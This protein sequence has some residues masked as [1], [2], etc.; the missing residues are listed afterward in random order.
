MIDGG[1]DNDV[2]IGGMDADVLHGSA[3]QDI[4]ISGTTEYDDSPED[5]AL[6]SGF[7]NFALPYAS[8]VDFLQTGVVFG[9][10]TISLEAN[11]NVLGDGVEDTLR[12]GEG[13]DWFFAEVIDGI[14][15]LEDGEVV[16]LL[17]VT[18]I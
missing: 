8:R 13:L 9:D 1:L 14:T 11:V 6:L 10:T 4:L 18:E 12:G 3:G 15:D 17:T 16:D 2:I 5:L 7:W